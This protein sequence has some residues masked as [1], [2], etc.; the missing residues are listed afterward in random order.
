VL[1][2]LK[3]KFDAKL[4]N[5]IMN[6]ERGA[7]LRLLYQL[8]LGIQKT[9]GSPVMQKTMTNIDEEKVNKKLEEMLQ[10][11]TTLPVTSKLSTINKSQKLQ[12]IEKH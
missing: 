6:E 1:R 12:I 10:L 2:E 7:A 3:V 8:K 4:I 9:T 5:Q 11:K